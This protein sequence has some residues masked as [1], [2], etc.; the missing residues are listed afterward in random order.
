[1]RMETSETVT[2]GSPHLVS[3]VDQVCR[4]ACFCP[5]S[6]PCL[7]AGAPILGAEQPA[8]GP[9]LR[10]YDRSGRLLEENRSIRAAGSRAP[11]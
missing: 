11:R 10:R 7:A 3:W 9:V 5:C 6:E 1:M 8:V 4:K 2:N